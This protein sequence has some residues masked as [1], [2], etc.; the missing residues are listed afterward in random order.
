MPQLNCPLVPKTGT[1]LN[2]LGIARISGVKQDE[3]SLEDQ[4]ALYRQRIEDEYAGPNELTMIASIGSGEILDREELMEAEAAIATGKFDL[5]IAEDLGRI[6]RRVQAL[7]FCELCEDVGTRLIAL[8]DDVDTAREGWRLNAFFAS[9][10]HEMYNA[11]TAKRIRRSLRHR[12]VEGGVVQYMV[13]GYVKPVRDPAEKPRRP[14]LDSEVT[15]DPAAEPVYDR[16]FD[17]LEG[18]AP[19]AEVADHLNESGVPTG[20]FCRS[21]RWTGR[22]VA[23]LVHNPILKGLRVRNAKVNKRVNKTGRRIS[24]TAPPGE[25]LER[26][27]PHLAFIDPARYDRVIALLATRN[28]HTRR[29]KVDG[30]DPRAG[31]SR[32]R[33]VWP[34]QHLFCDICG[35]LFYY[36]GHGQSEHLVCSGATHYQ[37]WNGIGVDGPV[38]ASKLMA[39]IR[40]EIAALPEF[41][42]ELVTAVCEELNGQRRHAD[43]EL[44][45]IRLRLKALDVEKSNIVLAIRSVKHSP[46]LLAE[47]ERLE[48]DESRLAARVRELASAKPAEVELPTADDMRRLAFEQFDA[49]AVGSP[50]FG[51]L[52]RRL[53]PR[54][55]VCPVRLCDG[56]DIVPRA[57]FTLDLAALV[58]PAVADTALGGVLRRE[59][60]VDLFD[61]P[62]REQFRRDAVRLTAEGL[63]PRAIAERLGVTLPPIQKALKLDKRM[64]ELALTDPYVPVTEPPDD[65]G[66]LRR[67]KHSRYCFE[68]LPDHRLG[69]P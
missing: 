1:V 5:V 21:R 16:M 12:F 52:L 32:K 44:R 31:V 4:E 55:V 66:M 28:A 39:A 35:R 65:Y 37:C 25:R 19:Y 47:L 34:G 68:P 64:H 54:I 61:P 58:P 41:D 8:N 53:I 13:Y 3:L 22:M 45:N 57:K 43:D 27:C 6:M 9:F 38:A 18:G 42:S 29:K 36:G 15:K 10:R 60:V 50:E 26:N 49:L 62:Q 63:K 33:T 56:G 14:I 2:V 40:T 23:Q 7:L 11:D 46:T 48:A 51:R 59:L 17:M 69:R 24:V 67:H 20:P 30:K